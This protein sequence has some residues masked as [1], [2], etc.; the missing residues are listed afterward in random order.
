MSDV[1]ELRVALTVA[2]FDEAVTFYRDRRR[3]V[4]SS[5]PAPRKW[6]LP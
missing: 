1:R 5:R 3:P 2:D 4:G 6:G